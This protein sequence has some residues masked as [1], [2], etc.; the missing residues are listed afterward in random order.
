[1]TNLPNNLLTKAQLRRNIRS[2]IDY[3]L[4]IATRQRD[5]WV[6]IIE[7]RAEPHRFHYF[8]NQRSIAQ[9]NIDEAKDNIASMRD[10]KKKLEDYIER[11]KRGPG[12]GGIA[13]PAGF[14]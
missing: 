5:R 1:M 2:E 4:R 11:A 7:S 12:G 13:M 10:I 14:N 9:G 8:D 3:P 6:E